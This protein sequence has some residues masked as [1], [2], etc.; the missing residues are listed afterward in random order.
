MMNSKRVDEPFTAESAFRIILT[1]Y[2]CFLYFTAVNHYFEIKQRQT[3][4]NKDIL[5]NE[6][7]FKH[8]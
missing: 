2:L 4:V 3:K 1:Y 8:T 5:T 6:N 7:Y